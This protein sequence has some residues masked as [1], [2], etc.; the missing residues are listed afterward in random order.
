MRAS[1]VV[2]LLLSWA[3]G[4][5]AHDA[6]YLVRGPQLPATLAANGYVQTATPADGGGVVVQV[7]TAFGPIGSRGPYAPVAGAA[8][9][10]VPS[11]FELPQDLRAKLTPDLSAWE[12][13]T[14]VLEWTAGRVAVDPKDLESQD[15]ASVLERGRGR[16]S[17]LAN[18]TAALLLAAGFEATTVS[19]LLVTESEAIPHRWVACRLPNAGWVHTDPTLGL[20][21]IT[22]SHLSFPETVTELPEIRIITQGSDRLEVL[23]RRSDRPLR[24]NVGSELGCR[25]ARDGGDATA[26]AVLTGVGGETY[27]VVLAPEGRFTAL[28]PGRWRL[29]VTEGE[30]VVDEAELLLRAGQ[31]HSYTVRLPPPAPGVEVGS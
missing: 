8:G 29:V 15:A 19:G 9:E 22:S 24:P 3:T 4:A 25:V 31:L 6:T 23:P 13:A 2:A 28:L 12:A 5:G 11:G 21:T 14:R 10:R 16:C 20:W 18:A 17:G 26:V 27:R 30:R 1:I 7:A